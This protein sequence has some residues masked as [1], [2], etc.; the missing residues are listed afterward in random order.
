MENLNY[1]I[2]DVKLLS[3]SRLYSSSFSRDGFYTLSG[4]R[5]CHW[6]SFRR[7]KKEKESNLKAR[8][9]ITT[10]SSS[11]AYRMGRF[12]RECKVGYTGFITLTYPNIQVNGK[13]AK[14]D[15]KVFIQRLKRL[16]SD[17]SRISGFWFLEFQ[18]NGNPHFH[19][20]INQ[21]ISRKLLSLIWYQVVDSGLQVHLKSGTKI[22][23]IRSGR[24]GMVS[25]ARKYA[26]KQAQK[27]IPEDYGW[28]GRFWGKFGDVSVIA[29]TVDDVFFNENMQNNKE[30]RI[31]GSNDMEEG[32]KQKKIFVF[33]GKIESAGVEFL[34]IEFNEWSQIRKMQ[35]DFYKC[36]MGK[37][38]YQSGWRLE[39]G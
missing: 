32:I 16:Y 11:S 30:K 33:K 37:P 2:N 14:R 1:L 27:E 38:D 20:F 23:K 22:E 35:I 36:V 34:I 5:I 39:N 25:Y 26:Q 4:N 29:V 24:H 15:I 21:W 7:K 17:K 18:S 12:L 28:S 9:G 6:S 19:L 31:F 3:Y 10:F 8:T 13:K